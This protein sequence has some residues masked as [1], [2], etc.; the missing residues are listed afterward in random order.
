MALLVRLPGLTAPEAERL[1]AARAAAGG[2]SSI[3]EMV[4]LADLPM[5]L[6]DR[7][8]DRLVLSPR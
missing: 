6:V 5:V 8:R 7:L 4:V 3:E 2:F 1:V